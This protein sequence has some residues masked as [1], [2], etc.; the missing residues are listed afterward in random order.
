MR[1]SQG[2]QDYRALETAFTKRMSHRWQA[3]VTY[4]LAF[5]Y[6]AD[7][8]P[9]N[10]GCEHPYTA[11]GVCNVP[12]TIAPFLFEPDLYLTGSQR[13]RAVVNGIWEAPFG[14]QVSG[15]FFFSDGGRGTTTS[16]L[17][18]LGL[19]VTTNRLRADGSLIPRNNFNQD[20][21]TRTDLR[22]QR[23]FNLPRGMGVDLFLEAFNA[24]N[25][26]TYSY[27]LNESNALFGQISGANQPRSGQ[28]GIRFTY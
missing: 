22:V 2:K 15:L 13:H 3:S 24:F 1:F 26:A 12:V 25:S 6:T 18:P 11:P 5:Q 14:L 20:N 9:V 8:Y 10:D 19:G 16:G 7:V 21:T 17:D 28:L 27:T 23:H 4:T